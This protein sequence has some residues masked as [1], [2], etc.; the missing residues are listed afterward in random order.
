MSFWKHLTTCEAISVPA[1]RKS[2]VRFIVNYA[3]IHKKCLFVVID[4]LNDAR[5]DNDDEIM[6][7]DDA[8]VKGIEES[9]IRNGLI[10][11]S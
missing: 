6:M 7:T 3:F 2:S 9:G 1:K 5:L 10:K 11:K 4:K 8:N